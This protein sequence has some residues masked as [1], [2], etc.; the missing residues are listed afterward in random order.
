MKKDK[1]KVQVEFKPDYEL[2]YNFTKLSRKGVVKLFRYLFQIEIPKDAEIT[3]SNTENVELNDFLGKLKN[4]RADII[5]DVGLERKLHIE[6]QSTLDSSIA[7]RVFFYGLYSG[8]EDGSCRFELPNSLILYTLQSKEQR[9]FERVEMGSGNC[10]FN[11]VPYKHGVW[12]VDIPY[13]NL[14]AIPL[15]DFEKEGLELLTYI[16]LYRYMKDKKLSRTDEDVKK[17]VAEIEFIVGKMSSVDDEDKGV[18]FHSLNSLI[19]DITNL[20]E[21]QENVSEEAKAMLAEQRMTISDLIELRG[22]QEGQQEGRFEV[23]KNMIKR[24]Y[25]FDE[26]MGVTGISLEEIKKISN[27]NIELNM[28]H[29]V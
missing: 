18:L 23:A 25:S 28:F 10:L 5:F 8:K 21:K 7:M 13:I 15:E 20:I 26:I 9:G 12:A 16:Y 11:G 4:T 1:G 17:I 2:K 14:L 19:V 22:R 24:S 27:G 3:L 6:F 29:R